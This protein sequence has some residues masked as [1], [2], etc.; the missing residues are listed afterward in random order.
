MPLT[1][2]RT[3]WA[4]S[5][6]VGCGGLFASV[7]ENDSIHGVMQCL[8]SMKQ[9]RIDV[10]RCHIPSKQPLWGGELHAW[11]CTLMAQAGGAQRLCLQ[12]LLQPFSVR[13][14]CLIHRDESVHEID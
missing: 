9:K 1:C 10:A 6:D 7:L 3:T 8:E 14:N 4:W 11:R 13:Q 5:N 2:V 12:G